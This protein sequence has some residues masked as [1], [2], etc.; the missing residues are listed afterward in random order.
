MAGHDIIVIGTSAGGVEALK[1]LIAELPA[2]LPASIFVVIHLPA[3]SKSLLPEILKRIS[4]MPVEAARNG[5][6]IEEGHIYIAP[7]NYHLIVEH[8]YMRIVRGPKENRHRPA[9]DPLFRSA[10][11][12]YGP[13]AI[14]VVLTGNLDDGTAG[15]QAIKQCG[16]ISMVQDPEEAAYPGMPRSAMENVIVDFCLPLARIPA[17]LIDLVNASAADENN[18][19]VPENIAIETSIA[20]METKDM[21]QVEHLGKP[22]SFTCPECSGTL[23][24][25]DDDQLLRFRCQVGHAYNGDSLQ[26][27]QQENLEDSLWAAVRALQE[28]AAMNRRMAVR[29]R[30]RNNNPLLAERFEEKARVSDQHAAQIRE[31]LT[32]SN[33]HLQKQ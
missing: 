20:R 28:V 5:I 26:A 23:W 27:D 31:I 9:V 12:A 2:D 15:M 11:L 21:T 33:E 32:Y 1:S 13:R 7:P 16:G 6:L 24:E 19:T 17:V 8:G 18:F 3:E 25:V 14:A 10:A 29:A 30:E 4:K 22:S